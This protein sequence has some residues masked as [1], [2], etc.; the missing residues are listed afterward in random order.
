MALPE[1][2]QESA[3]ETLNSQTEVAYLSFREGVLRVKVKENAE[4]SVKTMTELLGEAVRIAGFKKYFAIIDVRAGFHSE[5]DVRDYYSDNDYSK[6]RYADAFVVKSL[7]IRLM[8]NFYI[9]VNKP[10][11]PTKTFTD[12]EQAEK[13]IHDLKQRLN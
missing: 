1:N 8:V 6:Y 13:W 2:W 9:S 11:I 3:A 12:P 5:A 7:A 10:S 4:V